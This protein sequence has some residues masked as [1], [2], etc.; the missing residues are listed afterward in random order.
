ME[1]VTNVDRKSFE[2]A[3]A[4]VY[5]EYAKKFGKELLDGIKNTQ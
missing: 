3:V 4:P 5:P 1:V 2:E